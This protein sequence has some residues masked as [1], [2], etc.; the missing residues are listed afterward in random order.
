MLLIYK[1][2]IAKV[3]PQK[4]QSHLSPMKYIIFGEVNKNYPKY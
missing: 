3:L 4:E 2:D 1:V